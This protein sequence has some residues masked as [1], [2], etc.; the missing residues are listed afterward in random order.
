MEMIFLIVFKITLDPWEYHYFWS[1]WLYFLPFFLA[2][3]V[4]EK[5]SSLPTLLS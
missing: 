2:Q 1:L 4:I 5:T 3:T